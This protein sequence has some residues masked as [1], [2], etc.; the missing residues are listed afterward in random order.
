MTDVDADPPMVAQPY[1][2]WCTLVGEK[3]KWVDTG[4]VIGWAQTAF[5]DSSP[6]RDHAP[7]VATNDQYGSVKNVYTAQE[8]E[9]WF[10]ADSPEAAE[11]AAGRWLNR[12]R[13]ADDPSAFF[14]DPEGRVVEAPRS[15]ASDLGNYHLIV[16]ICPLTS[17]QPAKETP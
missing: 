5:S 9:Q 10:L 3:G 12:G 1:P 14:F 16:G 17:S 2:L 15:T 4:R 13:A 11:S 6:V 8:E 7:V